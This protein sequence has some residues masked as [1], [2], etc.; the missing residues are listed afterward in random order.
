MMLVIVMIELVVEQKMNILI[1][2]WTIEPYPLTI[3][4][5]DVFDI[6]FVCMAVYAKKRDRDG[7]RWK[8]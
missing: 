4:A 3:L 5:W 1:D 6:V 8:L 2:I 7:L